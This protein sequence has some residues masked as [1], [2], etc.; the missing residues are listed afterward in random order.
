MF[1]IKLIRENP[2]RV[3]QGL[4]AK[5]VSVPLD[6]I[7]K[8]DKERRS[9]QARADDLRSKQNT[10]NDEISKLLK[11]KKDAKA[12]IFAMKGISAQIDELQP[13]IKSLD[14][15]IDEILIGIPNLPHESVPVGGPDKSKIVRSWGT[16]AKFNFKP[17][18]HM[19]IA[20]ALDI[21][22]FKRAAKISGSNFILYKNAGARLERALYNFML[23]LHTSQHGY[24]EIFPPFLVNAAAMTGTGQLP[25]MKEDMYRLAED[26]LYLIPTAEV[27][28]EHS[29]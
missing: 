22:D 10:A 24:K 12:R 7:L 9:L 3:Q 16:P 29:S 28:V 21:I 2:D 14:E 13:K 25:K 8:L 18:T 1:D 5:N 4:K 23:D 6:E 20:E 15:K 11:E 19:E 26:E 27:P 17:K